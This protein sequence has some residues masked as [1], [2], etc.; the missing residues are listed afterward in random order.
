MCQRS[1]HSTVESHVRDLCA[2]VDKQHV[3]INELTL[4]TKVLI[5]IPIFFQSQF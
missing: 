4:A 1:L 2:L 3:R 5:F